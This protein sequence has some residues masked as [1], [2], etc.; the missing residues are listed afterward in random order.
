MTRINLVDPRCLADQHLFAE[1]REIK[2]IEPALV[3]SLSTQERSVVVAKIPPKYTLGAGHVL[4]FYDKRLYLLKR[5]KAIRAELRARGVDYNKAADDYSF[6]NLRRLVSRNYVP[7][8]EA[9]LIAC[10][11]IVEKLNMRPGWYRYRGEPFD[12]PEFQ[13]LVI[14]HHGTP[15]FLRNG[16]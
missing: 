13:R 4:F 7:D 11:R 5:Y 2:M 9:Y 14:E 15:K 16:Q 3:R 12:P 6:V 1:F 10:R 8:T